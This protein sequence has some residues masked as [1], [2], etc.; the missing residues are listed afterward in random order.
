MQGPRIALLLAVFTLMCIGLVM[1][2]S[3]SFA[4]LIVEGESAS[5][6]L[7]GQVRFAVLGVVAAI[8]LWKLLPYHVW[9]GRLI[10]VAWGLGFALILLTA[11]FGTD[12]Y[13]AKRWLELGPVSMQP[14]EFIKVSLLLMAIRIMYEMRQGFAEPRA[15]LVKAI[16][17]VLIPL[18]IMYKSQSDLGTTAICGV[19]ILAVMWLGGVPRRLIVAVLVA[20][21][22]FLAYSIF[23][24]DY[25]SGRMVY[26]DPW[27]DGQDGYGAGYNIIRSYYAIAEGGLFGVGLGGSHEKYQYLFA[28]ENDFIFAVV[29]EELGM[30]G[31][32]VVIGLFLVILVAGLRI[33]QNA[34]DDFG[35]MIAGGFTIML[36]FQAFLNIGCTIGVFPTTGKP[37]PFI[38]AGGTSLLAT[39]IMVGLILSV[40]SA[41]DAPSVYE[42]RRADL[43]VVRSTEPRAARPSASG[44]PTR[45]GERAPR[46]PRPRPKRGSA[47]DFHT[48][49]F[50]DSQ[51]L[52]AG[53]DGR[54]MASGIER[55]SPSR[56][57]R[58]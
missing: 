42:Q 43:R 56:G 40:S 49:S 14:S 30:V 25:R 23:G 41:S 52:G 46:A 50:A 4:N 37:L 57:T 9:T 33:A 47:A 8:V 48:I 5:A 17:F 31:A 1:V 12:A 51:R 15:L 20:A 54:M 7:V 3:A 24:T 27:N 55:R 21:G 38:S 19:G 16:V 35:T 44:R 22:L 11:V 34:P 58:R 45:P 28:S 39:M 53:R 10:W 13:G 18:L 2:Y 29:C 6:E 36:V 32:L 26:L